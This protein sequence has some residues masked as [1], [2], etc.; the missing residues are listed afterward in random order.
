MGKSCSCLNK[1]PK[2][3]TI[4]S[5]S[6]NL[7]HSTSPP[8]QHRCHKLTSDQ[9]ETINVLSTPSTSYIDSHPHKIP[10]II[11]I[12]Y[13]TSSTPTLSPS[14]STA[15]PT[16]VPDPIPNTNHILN[17]IPNPIRTIPNDG[18]PR[19]CKPVSNTADS[20][21]LVTIDT[22]LEY[23]NGNNV[24]VDDRDEDNYYRLNNTNSQSFI[25]FNIDESDLICDYY[26]DEDVFNDSELA[27]HRKITYG[28]ITKQ[29][30]EYNLNMPLCI[31]EMCREYYFA[32]T[33][34]RRKRVIFLS[35]VQL[36]LCIQ[37]I[38]KYILDESIFFFKVNK[39]S[40]IISFIKS[41]SDVDDEHVEEYL[42]NME[43]S[44]DSRS[45]T[46]GP[47]IPTTNSLSYIKDLQ[48]IFIEYL[49][50]KLDDNLLLL[51]DDDSSWNDINQQLMKIDDI[52]YNKDPYNTRN[53]NRKCYSSLILDCEYWNKIDVSQT[54]YNIDCMDMV[55]EIEYGS[56]KYSP[57]MEILWQSNP[58]L[59]P[60]KIFDMKQYHLQNGY[61]T[62]Y[63]RLNSKC[64]SRPAVRALTLQLASEDDDNNTHRYRSTSAQTM[65]MQSNHSITAANHGNSDLVI[66]S[67]YHSNDYSEISSKTSLCNQS[68]TVNGN[69]SKNQINNNMNINNS[70][71]SDI[72]LRIMMNNNVFAHL[73]NN[74]SNQSVNSIKFR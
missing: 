20:T 47:E 53:E 69:H 57:S 60:M 35:F 17:P 28:Y 33:P 46:P 9:S 42:E 63:I 65:Y 26:D 14:Q 45:R 7:L 18:R 31:M 72:D 52:W 2:E 13:T 37:K 49:K 24:G 34:I 29:T 66:L 61:N 21:K 3:H 74:L 54:K 50:Q 23:A 51:L 43:D 41:Q 44:S 25:G 39:A 71:I 6:N 70:N 16:T 32:V 8:T 38:P 48:P 15:I 22:L 58:S 19:L 68:Y 64:T 10:S 73:R 40:E 55:N 67:M 11:P 30:E 4:N 56:L 27:I 5:Y 12:D 59:I 62:E 1:L 36:N